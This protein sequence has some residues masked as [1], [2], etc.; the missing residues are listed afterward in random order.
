MSHRKTQQEFEEECRNLYGDLDDLTFAKYR[1]TSSKVK[2]VCRK[3]NIEY[4][5]TP[6]SHKSIVLVRCVFMKTKYLENKSYKRI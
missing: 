3:H 1:E 2:F 4:F 6:N 5:Q